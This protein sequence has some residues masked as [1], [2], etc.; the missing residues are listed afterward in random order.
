MLLKQTQGIN[1]TSKSERVRRHV[2]SHLLC[3]GRH[4]LTGLLG[5]SGRLFCDWSADYRMYSQNRIQPEK[6]F[7]PVRMTLANRL[8]PNEPVVVALDDTRL[9]KSGNKTY[10][11]KY[12]RD[13]LGPPFHVN[14]IKA[15]RFI[16][17][18]MA[19]P[20]QNGMAR[21][22]PIDF[23]HA[24]SP[25]KPRRKDDEQA[26]MDYRV[27]A[28]KMALPKVGSECVTRL[29]HALDH[30]G[31]AQRELWTVVDG[32]YTNRNFIQNLPPHTIAIGRIR[33]DAKLYHL[34]EPVNG[35]V[36][37]HR[38]YGERA[39]T[40]E[41]LRQD[42]SIPWQYI[43]AFATGKMH[44]FKIKT[45]APLRWRPA[46]KHYDLRLIV[47][48][49]LSYRLTQNSKL[50]YRKPA[51]LICTDPNADLQKILQAYLW[52]W[53]IEVNFRDEK[54]LLGV[55]EAQ[56][57]KANSVEKVPCLA[58]AAYSMLL[59]ASTMAFGPTGQPDHLP[60]PKWQNKPKI[61]PSTQTLIQ[62]LRQEVWSRS[63]NFSSFA[64]SDPQNT[65]PKK[66]ESTMETAVFYASG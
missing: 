10:G 41:K 12:V 56:V 65:K 8:H 2:L 44:Q 25:K 51:Y 21:M 38:V 48:A 64:Y 22:I 24:P 36:G 62:H 47:I 45:L 27:A 13:P 35:K 53:D 5:T 30:D 33:H 37:R 6:L 7:D 42:E 32:G 16:Q 4:T 9:P 23:V 63:M 31:H 11:V 55:G 52:R 18:S 43:P 39:P 66:L 34:P 49:P 60:A 15:Q 26:Q 46:G 20:A 58:V 29:R 14:F 59:T 40:P 61:R 3:M 19:S 57:R 50:L 28:R 1:G 17:I 54:T